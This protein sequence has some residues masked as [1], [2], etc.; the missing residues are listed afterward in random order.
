MLLNVVHLEAIAAPVI[1]VSQ[2]KTELPIE[3]D[4]PQKEMSNEKTEVEL[5]SSQN[6]SKS[7]EEDPLM[8]FSPVTDSG[9]IQLNSTQF[10]SFPFPFLTKQ[11]LS[12]FSDLSK[13]HLMDLK[14]LKFIS[15]AS[16]IKKTP[17]K[18]TYIRRTTGRP[19]KSNTK[20]K[21]DD[22]DTQ[23]ESAPSQISD[24]NAKQR[25]KPKRVTQIKNNNNTVMSTTKSKEVLISPSPKVIELSDHSNDPNFSQRVLMTIDVEDDT[26]R[27]SNE[28]YMSESISNLDNLSEDL[29]TKLNVNNRYHRKKFGKKVEK[30][31]S[32]HELIDDW[33]SRSSAES[34]N[35]NFY[36]KDL[37]EDSD[38]VSIISLDSKT[39]NT[40]IEE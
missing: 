19:R 3:T 24:C 40:E 23:S 28:T 33:E 38:C 1:T 2:I 5:P 17:A 20:K 26:S 14:T 9:K 13:N 18:R 37:P 10:T 30:G 39:E 36:P 27:H 32:I 16:P 31:V 29:K 21:N 34:E 25:P 15:N 22:S 12:S 7:D 4:T 8:A 6:D 11:F 35:T